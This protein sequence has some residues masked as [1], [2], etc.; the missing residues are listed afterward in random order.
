MAQAH[1]DFEGAPFNFDCVVRES[2][3][4][5]A[6]VTTHPVE[7]GS[8]V[9]DH[10]RAENATI[11][12]DILISN[13]PLKD[14]N[15][16]WGGSVAAL[17]LKVPRYERPLAPTPGSLM[18]AGLNALGN[19]LN[20]PEPIVATVMQ[21]PEKFNNCA[22]VLGTLLD[23]K[24]RGVVGKVV[25]SNRT[26]ENTV[27]T[28]VETTRTNTTGDAIEI[29]LSLQ[30]IRIV[31]AKLV[32]APVPT[33]TRGK[34]LKPKGRQPTAPVKDVPAKKSVFKKLLGGG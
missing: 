27:I 20:P 9:A 6:T 3:T 28:N 7:E 17:E 5:S 25:A 4:H 31:E 23:W 10:V 2:A 19:L 33:E 1:L 22:F 18:N 13:T 15:N 24:D 11:E 8:D 21:W 12:L 14:V 32:T 26:Y 34:T 30:E 29:K 16:V